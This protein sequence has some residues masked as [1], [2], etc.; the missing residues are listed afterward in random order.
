MHLGSV[1]RLTTNFPCS[2][3]HRFAG[4]RIPRRQLHNCSI[5]GCIEVTLQF[6]N[7]TCN[8][9]FSMVPSRQ[10]L[11]QEVKRI[12]AR[13]IVRSPIGADVC[14]IT[15]SKLLDRIG[16]GLGHVLSRGL[17]ITRLHR[18]L[19]S[20]ALRHLTTLSRSLWASCCIPASQTGSRFAKS[21]RIPHHHVLVLN[22]G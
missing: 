4:R 6:I 8:E 18:P 11:V 16:G 5:V 15:S 9:N 10:R 20:R 17:H 21:T 12:N 22:L 3:V 1:R 13:R 14:S 19:L 2:R 7:A